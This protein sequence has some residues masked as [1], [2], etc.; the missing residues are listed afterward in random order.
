MNLE[1]INILS[2]VVEDL[3][4]NAYESYAGSVKC[5]MKI[6]GEDRLSMTTMM[7]VNLGNR[8]AMQQAVKENEQSLKKI[9][10]DCLKRVKKDFKDRVGRALKSKEVSSDSSVELMNYH[11]YSEK[12]TC[13]IRQ[14]HVFE[15]S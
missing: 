1:E 11:A 5:I 3:Y 7:V 4:G 8:S 15:I 10:R 9:S 12:G 2:T 14:V 6:T 13:L